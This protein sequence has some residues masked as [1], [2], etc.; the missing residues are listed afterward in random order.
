MDPDHNFVL[1]LI[2]EYL[3]RAKFEFK[4]FSL[5]MNKNDDYG[6][7]VLKPPFLCK[8]WTTPNRT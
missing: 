4:A 8:I 2:K 7:S 1:Q 5:Q 6:Y 3:I